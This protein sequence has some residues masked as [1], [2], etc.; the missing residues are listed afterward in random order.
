MESAVSE[1]EAARTGHQPE[2]AALESSV[3]MTL[4]DQA[5]FDSLFLGTADPLSGLLES[6]RFSGLPRQHASR[7]L[8]TEYAVTDVNKLTVLARQRRSVGLSPE[9]TGGEPQRS[10]RYRGI[11]RQLGIEHELR[12]ALTCQG[13]CW[14]YVSLFR[15]NGRAD[16]SAAETSTVRA[17]AA[18]FSYELMK[19]A[20]NT[21]IGRLSPEQ[22]GV[23]SLDGKGRTEAV[24]D[25]GWYL[26]QHLNC[27]RC[28]QHPALPLALWTLTARLI[29]GAP[30]SSPSQRML[31]QDQNLGW[32]QLS[33]TRQR[34]RDGQP[35]A[36]VSIQ[37]ARPLVVA[38]FLLAAHGVTPRAVQVA[39]R[40]LRGMTSTEIAD[41]LQISRHT[42]QDHLRPVFRTLS[43]NSRRQLVSSLFPHLKPYELR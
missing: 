18:E 19:R 15:R 34:H 3:R 29:S 31:L 12:V 10:F 7:S 40:V 2:L 25:Y 41:D 9:A 38:P 30:D 39:L 17:W 8:L 26:L 36:T 37:G 32:L 42:V 35:Q 14:G 6:G 16:F 24:N 5:P 20:L 1:V 27:Q 4:A 43:V 21:P 22:I 11:L 23:I 28:P 33:G 13:V